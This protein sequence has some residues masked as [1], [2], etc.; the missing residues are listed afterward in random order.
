LCYP[1]YDDIARKP[2]PGIEKFE[3]IADVNKPLPLTAVE[4]A[5]VAELSAEF[6]TSCYAGVLML[7]AMG[8]GGYMYNGLDRHTILGASGDPN[9]PGLGFRY[10]TDERRWSLPNPTGSYYNT[11]YYS[12]NKQCYEV[13]R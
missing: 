5:S 3:N 7:Q 8:L 13:I 2:I 11:L 12:G 1:L 6:S 9:V 4:Q 10:D